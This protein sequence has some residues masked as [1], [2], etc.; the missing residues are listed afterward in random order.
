M[1]TQGSGHL[2]QRFVLRAVLLSLQQGS[3]Q[4]VHR[5]Y[6][7]SIIIT[8]L[9]IQPEIMRVAH[10]AP[11]LC[12]SGRGLLC[13]RV[14]HHQRYVGGRCQI[15]VK[16]LRSPAAETVKMRRKWPSI[17]QSHAA[18][19]CGL[20]AAHSGMPRSILPRKFIGQGGVQFEV[21]P[22]YPAESLLK[23]S[24]VG[25]RGMLHDHLCYG[26]RRLPAGGPPGYQ[27]QQQRKDGKGSFHQN[28]MV[29][30]P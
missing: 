10:A 29:Q 2:C 5:A 4:V 11:C 24:R 6:G 23:I 22:R 12:H 17:A 28:L 1:R 9:G 8:G 15:L 25:G 21:Y 7:A 13:D 3:Q 14:V 16:K 26:C 18:T 19:P 30:P 27:R 20:G